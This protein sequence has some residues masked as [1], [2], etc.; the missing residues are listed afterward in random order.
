VV[1]TKRSP[2]KPIQQKKQKYSDH[3]HQ[4]LGK[5]FKGIQ[6]GEKLN[7]TAQMGQRVS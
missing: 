1:E 7:Q 3:I 5:H 4:K 6:E 2:K